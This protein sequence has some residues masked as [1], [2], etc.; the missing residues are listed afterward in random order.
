[1]NPFQIAYL[2]TSGKKRLIK[3]SI[4]ELG[5]PWFF[6]LSRPG[7]VQCMNNVVLEKALQQASGVGIHSGD[8]N[9]RFIV[10]AGKL[11]GLQ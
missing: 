2:P 10:F 1:M 7:N 8:M 11:D 9:P 6:A 3:N 5:D 4:H